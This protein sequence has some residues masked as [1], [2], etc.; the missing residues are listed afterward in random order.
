MPSHPAASADAKWQFDFPTSDGVHYLMTF[1]APKTVPTKITLVYKIVGDGVF[2]FNPN[3][4]NA[5]AQVR[6][7]IERSD[8]DM[9]NEFGRWWAYPTTPRTFPLAIGTATI[10]VPMTP[11]NWSSVYGKKGT[12]AP[13]QFSDAIK[14]IGSVGMTFGGGCYAGHGVWIKSG[15][16]R[17]EFLDYKIQ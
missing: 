8:D 13:A 12:Q 17:F 14:H 9:I 5:P 7:M 4:C 2:T 10:T 11:D 16:A 15:H 6:L 1:F 3:G